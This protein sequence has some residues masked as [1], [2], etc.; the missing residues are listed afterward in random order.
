M[1]RCPIRPAIAVSGHKDTRNDPAYG[2]VLEPYINSQPARSYGNGTLTFAPVF[3]GEACL[4]SFAA[5]DNAK[6]AGGALV[7][8]E[9]GRPASVTVR[10]ASPYILTQARGEAA[11]A[12]AVEVSVDGGKTFKPAELKDFGAAVKGH[13]AALVRIG[14]KKALQSLKLEAVVQNNPGALPYLSPG[15]NQ[16]TVSVADPA[17]LGPN[18]LVVTYA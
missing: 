10:L 13:L 1:T 12:D 14:F 6:C 15:R 3:A 16:V 7:P 18:R 11:G 2:L 9:A 8:A 5:V 17:A 4:T